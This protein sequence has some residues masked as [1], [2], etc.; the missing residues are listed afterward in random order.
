[1]KEH[2][3]DRD[4]T[5][6]EN[7][8]PCVVQ[9]RSASNPRASRIRRLRIHTAECAPWGNRKQRPSEQSRDSVDGKHRMERNGCKEATKCGS[10]AHT[11]VYREPVQGKC[12]ATLIRRGDVGNG[13]ETGWAKHLAASGP[14]NGHG[15]NRGEAF[16]QREQQQHEA[17]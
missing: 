10:D 6:E 16:C 4:D 17:R 11:Q 1:L 14:E 9:D 8:K 15:R 3:A 2:D 12:L 5:G 13:G 7:E